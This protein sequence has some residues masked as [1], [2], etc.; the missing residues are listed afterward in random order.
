MD[1]FLPSFFGRLYFPSSNASYFP[2]SHTLSP[3][4]FLR[5]FLPLSLPPIRPFAIPYG[6]CNYTEHEPSR[7]LWN[8][9]IHRP[10]LVNALLS[11]YLRSIFVFQLEN[12]RIFAELAS[13][14]QQVN[15]RGD[16]VVSGAETA[17]TT[18]RS[19]SLP[20]TQH[21]IRADKSSRHWIA[22]CARA[23]AC[24][25]VCVLRCS[26]LSRKEVWKYVELSTKVGT[27]CDIGLSLMSINTHIPI[28]IRT[29]VNPNEDILTLQRTPSAR[30]SIPSSDEAY[31]S[32]IRTSLLTFVKRD[33][34]QKV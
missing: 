5:P 11:P 21:I 32:D 20:Y 10:T 12:E 33:A 18:N 9:R 30:H 14:L 17:Q 13:E 25:Y 4:T 31:S 29:S 7:H 16:R 2:S 1:T 34:T 15:L 22:V 24:V 23:R 3:P 6:R 26:E 27:V 28:R 19:I 8:C